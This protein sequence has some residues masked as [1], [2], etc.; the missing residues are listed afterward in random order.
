MRDGIRIGMKNGW[1]VQIEVNFETLCLQHRLPKLNGTR[2]DFVDRDRLG[3][4]GEFI[5]LLAGIIEH[6]LDEPV[7]A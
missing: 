4:D 2:G 6:V 3:G 5:P 7:E 1:P